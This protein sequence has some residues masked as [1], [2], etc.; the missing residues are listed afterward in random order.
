MSGSA[1]PYT[2]EFY[3]DPSTERVLAREWITK[4]LTRYQRLGI[5]GGKASG[6]WH[7]QLTQTTSWTRVLT[8]LLNSFENLLDRGRIGPW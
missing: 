8:G 1:R 3:D 5:G 6:P 2:I 7:K 4:E